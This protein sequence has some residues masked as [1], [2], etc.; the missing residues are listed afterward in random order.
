MDLS[1]SLKYIT[2]NEE[3]QA[4]LRKNMEDH[5]YKSNLELDESCPRRAHLLL[6]TLKVFWDTLFRIREL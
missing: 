1:G 5:M 2:V 3:V 6:F 4:I